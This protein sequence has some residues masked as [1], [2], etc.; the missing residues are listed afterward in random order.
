VLKYIR[1]GDGFVPNFDMFAK[2]DVNGKDQNPIYEFLKSRCRP[3]REEFSAM[4]KYYYEPF[5]A[6]DIRWNFE[7]FLI[8]GNG[9]PVRRYD[10]SLDPMDIEPD[11]IEQLEALNENSMPHHGHE[12]QEHGHNHTEHFDS[13][14]FMEG[15]QH[16]QM[17]GDQHHHMEGD[18]HMAGDQHQHME[19]DQHQHMEGDQH[20]HMEG[21]QHQHMKSSNST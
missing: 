10:E 6:R 9:N 8:D 3:P 20:H 14:S 16:Q 15:D 13:A 17:A 12:H 19:G 7:K 5:H 21:D 11:I 1:P 18:Q 2:T 4:K